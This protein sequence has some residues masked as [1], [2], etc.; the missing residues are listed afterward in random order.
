MFFNVIVRISLR[1]CL[2]TMKEK[3][4]MHWLVSAPAPEL[5]IPEELSSDMHAWFK[6]ITHSDKLCLKKSH[7][8]YPSEYAVG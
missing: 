2:Q 3:K 5:H 1:Y 6:G 7:R 8:G 4:Q